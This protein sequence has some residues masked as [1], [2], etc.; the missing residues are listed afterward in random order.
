MLSRTLW[1]TLLV[2]VLVAP[3]RGSETFEQA[4]RSTGYDVAE[5]LKQHQARSVVPRFEGLPTMPGGGGAAYVEV[6]KDSL[7]RQDVQI[8]SRA[9]HAVVSRLEL[10]TDLRGEKSMQLVSTIRDKD[11]KDVHEIRA[12]PHITDG[13]ELAETVGVPV[14]FGPAKNGDARRASFLKNLE[15]AT[16]FTAADGYQVASWERGPYR[17]AIEVNGEPRPFHNQD[18]L[19]FTYL[20]EGET[21]TLTLIN[22]SNAEAAV[23]VKVDGLNVFH[24]SDPSDVRPDGSKYRY[25]IVAPR[26][27]LVVKGWQKTASTASEFHVTPLEE[28][29]AAQ[30][31][32]PLDNVGLE[33]ATF[34]ASWPQNRRQPGDE[35]AVERRVD[36]PV[37]TSRVIQLPD[38]TRQT[39]QEMKV[40]SRVSTGFGAEV[41]VNARGVNRMIGVPRATVAFRYE[42][43]EQAASR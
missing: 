17:M 35:P 30:A 42:R 39:V 41:L 16:Y 20:N 32:I 8:S 5:Y 43:G 18:G 27:K 25:W 9:D 15:R 26:R 2:A 3:V 37:T 36:A 21:Y 29:A 12:F 4:I 33:T 34:Y 19:P 13:K 31:G 40:N 38:G 23:E 14:H 6:L 22:D 7:A 24:F 11:G 28:G 1:L 10:V